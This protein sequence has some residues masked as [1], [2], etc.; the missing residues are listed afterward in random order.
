[1]NDIIQEK[2]NYISK[3][4]GDISKGYPLIEG[5]IPSCTYIILGLSDYMVLANDSARDDDEIDISNVYLLPDNITINVNVK[6]F[7][8]HLSDLR[9]EIHEEI[10]EWYYDNIGDGFMFENIEFREEINKNINLVGSELPQMILN[11]F[12]FI[13]HFLLYGSLK[14]DYQK[15]EEAISILNA[16]A[17]PCSYVEGD[18]WISYWPHEEEPV[19]ES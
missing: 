19:W 13:I 11:N 3:V 14:E 10:T 4:I 7:Y 17:I 8:Q 12:S 9:R 5:K 6:P 18:R 2:I 15:Y 1:M 16:G